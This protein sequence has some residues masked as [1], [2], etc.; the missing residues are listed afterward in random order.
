MICPNCGKK[1]PF[2]AQFCPHCGTA[3][4]EKPK[5]DTPAPSENISTESS[6]QPAARPS[7]TP[8]GKKVLL[9]VLG[10]VILLAVLLFALWPKSNPSVPTAPSNAQLQQ[11]SVQLQESDVLVP[12]PVSF[13]QLKEGQFDSDELNFYFYLSGNGGKPLKAYERLARYGSYDLE[14]D[15]TTNSYEEYSF[16]IWLS[17]S[18]EEKPFFSLVLYTKYFPEIDVSYILIS[19]VEGANPVT[20]FWI[21]PGS[22]CM[23]DRSSCQ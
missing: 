5:A 10:V 6:Q 18:N 16:V 3:Q 20:P 14:Y 23:L 12:D 2:H 19:F 15:F 4:K 13:F 11:T 17:S 1:I 8:Q 21:D 9:L 22:T 7:L